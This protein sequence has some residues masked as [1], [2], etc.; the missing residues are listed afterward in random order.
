MPTA[1]AWTRLPRRRATRSPP[2]PPTQ[3]QAHFTKCD[4]F[5]LPIQLTPAAMLPC[6]TFPPAREPSAS[7]AD[8]YSLAA[9][10]LRPDGRHLI[11]INGAGP[12]TYR[13]FVIKRSLLPVVRS[14]RLYAARHRGS[15][16]RE[17]RLRRATAGR[18]RHS[19][20]KAARRGRIQRRAVYGLLRSLNPTPPP[21]SPPCTLGSASRTPGRR[22]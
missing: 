15:I 20:S 19:R 22:R 13:P 1:P 14:P 10:Q 17:S 8:H 9:R 6:R 11:V 21:R 4:Y 7:R 18:M 5:H 2:S 12:Q 16:S 3:P